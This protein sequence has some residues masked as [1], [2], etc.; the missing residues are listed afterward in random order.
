MSFVS[1]P[2]ELQFVRMP[3]SP[4]S[5]PAHG[6]RLEVT[7]KGFHGSTVGTPPTWLKV[8]PDRG[9]LA[10]GGSFEIAL[11]PSDEAFSLPPGAYEGEVKLKN[12]STGEIVKTKIDLYII[13][14]GHQSQ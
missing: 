12:Y 8:I 4:F 14:D 5:P 3:G 2:H 6:L 10:A 11:R 13:D 1:T 7:G 9:D